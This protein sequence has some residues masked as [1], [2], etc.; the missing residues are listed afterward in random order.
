MEHE[1]AG[2]IVERGREVASIGGGL[3][4]WATGAGIA[5]VVAVLAGSWWLGVPSSDGLVPSPSPSSPAPV[6]LLRIDAA[7]NRSTDEVRDRYLG[8]GGNVGAVVADRTLWQL[9]VAHAVR[10]DVATG[11]V[12]QAR[13]LPGNTT[14]TAVAFGSLWHV[15]S[16]ILGATLVR[17]DPASGGIGAEIAIER[18]VVDVAVGGGR[19]W[20]LLQGG[21]L[22][23]VDPERTA[24]VATHETH[25]S[26]PSFI[27][28]V[29]EDVWIC[30]CRD[31]LLVRF[32]P[33]TGEREEL[34]LGVLRPSA[35][36]RDSRILSE[37]DD[38]TIW[39][40]DA[41]G[42]TVTPFD[43]V[44]GV[45]GETLDIP[46]GVAVGGPSAGIAFGLG[47]IW[48]VSSE[49]VHRIDIE[50]R[51]MEV[52]RAPDGVELGGVAVDEESGVVWAVACDC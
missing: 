38:R 12:V 9:T 24:V 16:D 5:L 45:L 37:V 27:V 30:G 33:R 10:R 40:V 23:E 8:I 42:T 28:A 32:D 47:S 11:E 50:T 34:D 3:G 7:T 52:I 21:E 29:G 31:G 14:T 35:P 36:L 41:Q 49:A 26:P 44:T 39:L 17:V 46:P 19:I 6:T 2:E 48:L 25:A 13:T 15:T 43:T 51:R 1:G 18:T 22:L 4:A 20:L